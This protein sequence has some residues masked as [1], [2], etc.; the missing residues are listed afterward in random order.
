MKK[1]YFFFFEKINLKLR[2]KNTQLKHLFFKSKKTNF[3]INLKKN[4]TLNLNF[5]KEN[6]YLKK[7]IFL[8]KQHLMFLI[9]MLLNE[10]EVKKINIYINTLYADNEKFNFLSK[11]THKEE[12]LHFFMKPFLILIENT[13]K[14]NI[15]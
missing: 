13:K 9:K 10:I 1:K 7:N 11:V 8:I 14:N 15:A 12:L 6:L 2:G 3:P 5:F 4:V